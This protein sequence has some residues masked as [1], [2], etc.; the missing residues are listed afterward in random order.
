[1]KVCYR[2]IG[3]FARER[4]KKPEQK[5]MKTNLIDS[6]VRKGWKCGMGVE[7][8]SGQVSG[9]G[10]NK[11]TDLISGNGIFRLKHNRL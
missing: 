3:I 7:V 1:M 11:E 5:G 6:N 4:K 2:R 8:E 9:G 10:K